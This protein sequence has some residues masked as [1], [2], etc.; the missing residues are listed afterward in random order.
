M[1]TNNI[2]NVVLIGAS[3]LALA[4]CGDKLEDS[5]KFEVQAPLRFEVQT[6]ISSQFPAGSNCDNEPI[7]SRIKCSCS[8]LNSINANKFS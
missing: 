8:Q 4:G 3:A 6:S 2:K 5:N 1:V 7:E